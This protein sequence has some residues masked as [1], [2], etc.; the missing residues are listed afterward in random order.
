MDHNMDKT[1][2]LYALINQYEQIRKS[3]DRLDY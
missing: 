3:Y 2:V 1:D